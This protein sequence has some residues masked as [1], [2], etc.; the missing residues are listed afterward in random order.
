MLAFFDVMFDVVFLSVITLA[1]RLGGRYER[2]LALIHGTGW[3]VVKASQRLSEDHLPMAAYVS[4]DVGL[5]LG[6]VWLLTRTRAAWLV[7]SLAAQVLFFALEAAQV[8][9]FLPTI[10]FSHAA[11]VLGYFQLGCL[12]YAVL[13]RQF[14]PPF[15]SA[16]AGS[17]NG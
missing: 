1:V 2:F 4:I 13:R 7:C 9:R 8:L 11:A 14:G 6:H 17:A 12:A 5:L 3:I 16:A 10:W 15:V